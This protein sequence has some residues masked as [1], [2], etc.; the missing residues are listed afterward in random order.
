MSRQTYIHVFSVLL[1]VIVLLS[2][3]GGAPASAAASFQSTPTVVPPTQVG[4]S[5][6]VVQPGA[7]PQAWLDGSVDVNQFAPLQPL[8]V[9]FNTPMSAAS[10]PNPVL[11]WPQVEGVSSWDSAFTV[12]TFTPGVALDN[13]KA[14]TFFL[15]PSLRSSA[16]D[17]IKN[18]PEWIV[19]VQSG[20]EVKAVS[21]RPGSLEQRSGVIEVHFDREMKQIVSDSMLSIEPRVP[22]QLKWKNDQILQVILEQPFKPD[23]RYDLML[24]GGN[25]EHALFAEDGTYL[26]DDYSWF[27]W[28]KPFAPNVTVPSSKHVSVKFNYALDQDKNS[29]PFSI[30]PSLAGEWTWISP[31]EL[32]FASKETIPTAQQ[33]TLNLERALVDANGFEIADVP[34]LTFT[35]MPPVRLV[36]ADIEGEAI[37]IEFDVPVDHASAEAAFSLDPYLPGTFRWEQASESIEET[38]VYSLRQLP[39]LSTTYAIAI[40]PTVQ[41]RRGN[42]IILQP[43]QQSFTTPSWMYLSPT[44]G[45]WGD[46]IQ[47][48]DANGP[49]RVQFAG[50]DEGTNFVAYS[51]DLIDFARLYADH[52]HTR[53]EGGNV[54]DI[55]IP[56]ELEPS[57]TWTNIDS[58]E[59]REGT[60]TETILPTDL[61]PGLYILNM[62]KGNVLYDQMFLALTSNTLVVK[63]NGDELFAWLTDIN[64]ESI[65]DAE[66]RL[67]SKTGEKVREGKTD[68]NG[69]YRVS[70]PRGVGPMLVSARIDTAGLAGDVAVAGFDGWES[71]F[72]YVYRDPASSLPEGRPYLTH[73]YTERPIYRPG[74]VVNFKGIIRQDD[75]ARYTLLEEGTPVRVRVLDARGNALE[76]MELL[77]NP[78]GS[79]H[80]TTSIAEGAM[81][82]DYKIEM[83]V[84][85]VITSQTFKVEDYRKPD[86]QLTLTS[87]QP[88]KEDKFVRGEEMKIKVNASYYFGEPLTNT[89]L[90]VQFFHE[91]LLDAR[92]RSAVV[93]DENGEAT[94]TFPA[95]YDPNY[96]DYY[97]WDSSSHPQ[98]I[99]MQVTANDGSN[100]TVTGVYSFS[101]Y[102]AAEQ[103][104]LDTGGYFANPNDPFTVTARALDLFGQPVAGRKLSLNI[105][106]WNQVTFDFNRPEQVVDLRTDEHGIATRE[107]RL[108]SGY[109]QVT[110]RGK[111]SK[112]RDME[113]SRWVYVFRSGEE[114]FQ[115]SQEEFLMIS[116]EK[117]SYKPYETA[118][119]AI[120]STFSGP[121]LLTFERGSVI[122]TKTIELTA[123]LTI[124]E[125]EI[126]PEHAPNVY[127]T[128]NAWQAA[129]EEVGRSR[130]T[131]FME[132]QAD[133]FL[134][135][136]KTQVRV[137]STASA[138][139]IRIATE[140]QTYAPGETMDAVIEVRDAAGNPV[141]AELSL[142]VV[143]ESIF[144]LAS[145]PSGDIFDAFYGP[146]AHSVT[147]FNSMAPVRVLMSGGMGGG[148]DEGFVAPRSEFLDTAAWLPIIETD[149]NGQATVSVDLP[150]N[151]TSWRLTVKAVTLDHKVGQAQRNIETK[152]ELFLRPVLPR[153][154]TDGD[155]A[156]LTTFVHNYSTE[157]QTLTVDL[158]S[159]GLEIRSS[160][161]VQVTVRPGEVTALGW[162]VRALS[163][164]PTEVTVTARNA[165]G[166]VDAV[167]LPLQLQPAAVKDVQNQSG[168]FTGTLTLGLPLPDV[169]RETSLVRLSLNRSMSGT[170]LNGLEYLTGYPYGCVEQTMSRA[171]PNAVVAR[172][173]DQL[174]VGGPELQARL[175]PLIQSS[176]QRLY[177]LQ[178]SDGG[179]GWWTDDISDPY[180]TAWV[181][182]GLGVMD[183]SGYTV[184][185]KVM[186]RAAKWLQENLS[187]NSQLD[188]RTRAYALYSMAQAGRG[189]LERT[190]ALVASSIY[191]LD[192]FSQAAL[193]LALH[194]LGETEEARAILGLLSTSA[195]K[196]DEYVYWPQPSYDGQYHSKTMASTVRTTAL[197]LLAYAEIDPESDLLAGI[198]KYLAEER[199]GMYGWG[200]TN[201]T[202]FTILALTQHLVHEE[203]R[204][205]N[206]PYEVVVNG[207]RLASGT[208]EV[209]NSSVGIDIPLGELKDG[210]NTLL[211]TTQGEDPVYFDLSTRYDVLQ[212]NVEPAGNI[213]VTR[214]YLNPKTK[215]PIEELQAGQLVLVELRVDVPEDAFFLAV[216]DYLPG[217]LEALNEGL[218]AVSEVSV[219][220]WGFEEYRPLFWEDYGYNYKEIRGDRVVFFITSFGKGSDTFTYYA[221][222]TTPGEFIA[223]PAQAYAMYDLSLWGRS[224]SMNIEINK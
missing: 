157:T 123:P 44:F 191:E 17:E 63:N 28:Q 83:D 93:T 127:I 141:P 172:A 205:G 144:A 5:T 59:A 168:Q 189:D 6:P 117:D 131:S 196:Q 185:P 60:V 204:A 69:Q 86:Y 14:Y 109:H 50:T 147:T 135:L 57:A 30:S 66:V 129:S 1:I 201:E 13:K 118:R 223:L 194:Q 119:L 103:L 2:S 188:I 107:L 8:V 9:H 200:T 175:D 52:Y 84:N 184:E 88:E 178:H 174:G 78:Y 183:R 210:S 106:S 42:K 208:L 45:E 161:N 77:T 3:V 75:D 211:V 81:L 7:E 62:R 207:E 15:D 38:L 55:P 164:K 155:Q 26:A 152:K 94:I 169:E 136:A 124:V 203:A 36:N 140:K 74:Q 116:A 49:R 100:Q 104:R 195:R 158:A 170:L 72:P 193:A 98:Q 162:Q 137:D 18:P 187:N 160:R 216:E 215:K 32:R 20:P 101:V 29:I 47:V 37:R 40:Q 209:G 24:N 56:S 112:G 148:G 179:W 180:Q 108:G 31:H 139:D 70:I 85:G 146:R 130:Y 33:F 110:L 46:N 153:V 220:A 213:Q 11:S 76:T 58:R 43:Y 150:D 67:Y 176:I 165:A 199:Q 92:V 192:P 221:R 51:F 197:A 99:R 132:T 143:D 4:T 80:G 177:G 138:L 186:D 126:I 224:G 22:F 171:L 79:V 154:L 27:Y 73:I 82:G 166:I 25:D 10:S 95:P 142:A 218:N 61:A 121:A 89:R 122:N 206:T 35:G 151:T 219:G 159:A 145:D 115:R 181:L 198:V 97:Y 65:P 113:I 202:S 54:R 163:A 134:R 39:E 19:R 71:Y 87:L 96:N 102:P 217:G 133:S 212:S 114:W 68:E 182:F 91:W 21:P 111:D 173:A 120:E 128:V 48:V 156:T 149:A 34:A 105:S 125:T 41:D 23:Q 190:Q 167:L 214:R 64:G 222:A 12:L 16:G 53:G 90:N